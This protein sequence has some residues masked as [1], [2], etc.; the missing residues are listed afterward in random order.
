MYIRITPC[1]GSL[2]PGQI[3]LGIRN[4]SDQV[5][6]EEVTDGRVVRGGVSVT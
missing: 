2:N 1:L 5:V 6:L 4:I 3:E